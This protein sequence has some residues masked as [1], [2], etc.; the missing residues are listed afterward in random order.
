M[1]VLDEEGRI[2]QWVYRRSLATVE[3]GTRWLW[4][5]NA[6]QL[7]LGIEQFVREAAE[8]SG[9]GPSPVRRP[10]SA[11]TTALPPLP[12]RPCAPLTRPAARPLP[13]PPRVPVRR[14]AHILPGCPHSWPAALTS[15]L[16]ARAPGRPRTRLCPAARPPLLARARCHASRATAALLR[17][18][19]PLYK[20][21]HRRTAPP[22]TSRTA[23]PISLD[24]SRVREDGGRGGNTRGVLELR[25]RC[26]LQCVP[27]LPPYSRPCAVAA[28]LAPVHLLL[29]TCA[30]VYLPARACVRPPPPL[31][32]HVHLC[33]TGCSAGRLKG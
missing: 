28:A 19:L 13:G 10:Q 21:R 12:G 22:M 8:S 23:S 25:R 5:I 1:P 9:R 20:P 3:T 30:R 17:P 2:F 29:L 6:K 31:L 26:L 11:A 32:A 27:R 16:V 14:R 15:C 18:H 33:G 24:R 4:R 7:R